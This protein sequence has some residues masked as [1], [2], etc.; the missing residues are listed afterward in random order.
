MKHTGSYLIQEGHI[1]IIVR[2]NHLDGDSDTLTGLSVGSTEGEGLSVR[3]HAIKKQPSRTTAPYN[4]VHVQ[5]RLC[6]EIM[7]CQIMHI[8]AM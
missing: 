8:T 3:L 7:M 1:T 2:N 4:F 5:H 6:K